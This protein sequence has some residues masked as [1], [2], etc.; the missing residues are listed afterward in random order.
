[1]SDDANLNAYLDRVGFA[2]S[3]APNLETLR[4]LHA[5]HPAAIPFENL[6]P[7]LDLPV[8]LDQKSLEQKLIHERR[9]GYCY[10]HNLL[11]MRVLR[12]LGYEVKGL[13]ARVLWGRP[14]DAIT[15][16]NHMLINVD[17]GGSSYIVDVGFGGLTP[18]APLR[19]RAGV[20]QQTPHETFRITGEE[21]DFRVEAQIGEEWRPLYRFDLAEHYELDYAAPNW[22]L[23]TYPES[24][25]R[26]MLMVNRAEKGRRLS[27]RNADFT[28]RPTGG[29][30][31][32]RKL[33][34]V[35]E[36]REVLGGPFG[37]ALPPTERLDPMLERILALPE[38][39]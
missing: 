18:T 10:E 27:L 11:F 26:N 3:I 37:I 13:A 38:P 9:G 23:S 20:E 8:R 35:A 33:T 28:T 30:A 2:G 32:T 1:M 39:R 29:E 4:T 12:T 24:P 25:F 7:L 36:L 34:S 21:P 14:P 17:I 16:R 22:Y 6:S 31:E 5:A 19:L 15:P